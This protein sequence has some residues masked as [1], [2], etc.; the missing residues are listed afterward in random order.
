MKKLSF[1]LSFKPQH[2]HNKCQRTMAPRVKSV[3]TKQLQKECKTFF[4]RPHKI[5]KF[6]LSCITLCFQSGA[7]W[8][9]LISA[10]VYPNWKTNNCKVE[11]SE[12]K[13]WRSFVEGHLCV[14]V[15]LSFLRLLLL[16]YKIH[17]HK[18][19]GYPK[20]SNFLVNTTIRQEIKQLGI[21]FC[22]I[23]VVFSYEIRWG[24]HL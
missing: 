21:S 17:K 4:S 1:A 2:K 11:I 16:P 15:T 10:N 14:D 13:F 22:C 8:H 5:T 12:Q 20:I 24:P 19:Q 7:S 18:L 9:G 23:F 6:M 3:C